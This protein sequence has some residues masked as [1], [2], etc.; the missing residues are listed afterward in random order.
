MP[1]VKVNLFATL[2]RFVDGKPSVEVEIA[3]GDTVAQVLDRL[4]VPAEQARVVF[5]DN[6]AA[7]LNSVL[8]GDE[9]LGVFPAVGGG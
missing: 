8:S 5:V 3:P 9:E 2:R 6:Q 1:Q 7:G 4:G